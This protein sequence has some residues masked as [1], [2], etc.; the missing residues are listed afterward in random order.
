M[1]LIENPRTNRLCE[2][3][4]ANEIKFAFAT[5]IKDD[6]FQLIHTWVKCR[7]YFNELLMKNYHPEEFS[8]DEI[9]GFQYEYDKYPMDMTRTIVALKF[10]SQESMLRCLDN[11]DII[12]KIEEKNDVVE[13]TVMYQCTTHPQT[14]LIIASKFWIQKALLLNL[15]TMML[16]VISNNLKEKDIIQLSHEFITK[17]GRNPA[18]FEYIN[19]I[20]IKKFNKILDNLD[21]IAMT[22]TKYVDGS[23]E[24]RPPYTI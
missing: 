9:H 15:Y 16:K 2:S 18:E 10:P 3:F 14:L 23:S 12:H 7:E 20:T 13:R 5:H 4:Q 1:K 19:R 17:V 22:P 6:D 24:I 21:V 11:I 8:F